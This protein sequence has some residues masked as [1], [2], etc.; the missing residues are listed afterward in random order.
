[1]GVIYSSTSFLGMTNMMVGGSITS[2]ES[3]RAYGRRGILVAIN[4]LARSTT[5]RAQNS[6]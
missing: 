4:I 1:M 6:A 2:T 3:F 5:G